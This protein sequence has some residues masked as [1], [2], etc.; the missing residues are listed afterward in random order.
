MDIDLRHNEL[1]DLRARIAGHDA[2]IALRDVRIAELLAEIAWRDKVIA[3]QRARIGEGF[4]GEVR[5]F[6]DSIKDMLT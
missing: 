5:Q 6:S 3:K 1:A 4:R 2:E